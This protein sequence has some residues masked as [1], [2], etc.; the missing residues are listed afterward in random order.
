MTQGQVL[1]RPIL[2]SRNFAAGGL[3][4]VSLPI[5]LRSPD[6]GKIQFFDEWLKK[7]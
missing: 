7:L 5:G 4:G 6:D 1:K 2:L 3:R